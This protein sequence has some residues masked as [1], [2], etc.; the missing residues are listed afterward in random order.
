MSV[1]LRVNEPF[2][3]YMNQDCLSHEVSV[4]LTDVVQTVVHPDLQMI[5]SS[6]YM[7]GV[8]S[9][10]VQTFAQLHKLWTKPRMLIN[11][12]S[13][14]MNLFVPGII[15]ARIRRMGKVMFSQVSVRPPGWG[16]GA[17]PQSQPGRYPRKRV[18]RVA[19]F[20]LVQN[21][22]TFPWQFP[23]ISSFFPDNLSYF[24]KLETRIV[25]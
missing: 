5:S 25:H 24:S 9:V 20:E 3:D 13:H 23:D 4:I 10:V 21:S 22:L 11:I 12:V 8:P 2:N 14:R 7:Q 18:S 1:S 19:T 16:G 17:L 15:T 6:L